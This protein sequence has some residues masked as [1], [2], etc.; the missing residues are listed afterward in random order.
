MRCFYC[1]VHLVGLEDDAPCVCAACF[2]QM[3]KG[4]DTALRELK[5][6]TKRAEDL[7]RQLRILGHVPS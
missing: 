1:A 7:E 2:P 5:D 3:V 6:M 4:Y